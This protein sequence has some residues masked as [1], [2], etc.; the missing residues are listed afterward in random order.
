LSSAPL[1]FGRFAEN[2]IRGA[3]DRLQDGLAGM[4]R[5]LQTERL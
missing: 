5:L 3:G 2:V 4:K 1:P